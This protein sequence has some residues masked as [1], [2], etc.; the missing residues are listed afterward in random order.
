MTADWQPFIQVNIYGRTLRELQQEGIALK[1]VL[2]N[3]GC[4]KLWI[5]EGSMY[6]GMDTET[7]YASSIDSEPEPL[8]TTIANVNVPRLSTPI[9]SKFDRRQFTMDFTE[10]ISYIHSPDEME[11][12]RKFESQIQ[13]D[14]SDHGSSSPSSPTD[15]NVVKNLLEQ[16]VQNVCEEERNRESRRD[17]TI[18]KENTRMYQSSS[19]TETDERSPPST[20]KRKLTTAGVHQYKF[21]SDSDPDI[22]D[23]EYSQS[24]L[25]PAIMRRMT[26]AK[27]YTNLN[28][29]SQEHWNCPIAAEFDEIAPHYPWEEEEDADEFYSMHDDVTE[30]MNLD[31]TIEMHTPPPPNVQI[32]RSIL[33]MNVSLE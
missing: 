10:N 19:R 24:A 4:S 28:P 22:C 18:D 13:C 9:Y 7:E 30:I 32:A 26:S 21:E 8:S 27:V 16:L 1:S 12:E 3:I 17:N 15:E 20:L 25:T 23:L 29:V 33:R 6:G 11:S 5:V 2:N 31:E 14:T